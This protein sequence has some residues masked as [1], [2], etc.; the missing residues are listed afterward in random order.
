[1]KIAH[2]KD[3]LGQ[4]AIRHFEITLKMFNSSMG[5]CLPT[6]LALNIVVSGDH[7]K[8]LDNWGE[9]DQEPEET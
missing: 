4:S 9:E 3:E 7:E 8:E 2:K 5:L 6:K 1:M